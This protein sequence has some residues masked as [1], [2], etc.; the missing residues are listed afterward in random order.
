MCFLYLTSKS[1]K[2]IVLM[3]QWF[4]E[5]I[6]ADSSYIIRYFVQLLKVCVKLSRCC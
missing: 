5:K 1:T 6:F 3:V 4:Q 2:F